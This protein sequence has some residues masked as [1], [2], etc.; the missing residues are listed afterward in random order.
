MIRN[1]AFLVFM[2][3]LSIDAYPQLGTPPSPV[4]GTLAA[5]LP[6]SG[7][8][9]Q[10]GSVTAIQTPI[11]G[12]TTSVNTINPA[13][14][15]QGP[16]TGS[17]PSTRAAPFS[18]KLSLA[19]AMERGLGYNLGPIGLNEILNQARGQKRV[20]RSFLHP[21][22]YCSVTEAVQETSLRAFGL[23]ST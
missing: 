12:T 7:R 18:G 16:Y 11:P 14:Q 15:V 23:R 4:Q 22:I 3:M 17:T 5:T 6:V 21:N 10:N 1:T 9:P 8:N 13:I 19:D 2:L 20:Y